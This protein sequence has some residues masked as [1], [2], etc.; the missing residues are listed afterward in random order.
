MNIHNNY[1]GDKKYSDY[2]AC[3]F[4]IEKNAT[5]VCMYIIFFLH[6]LLKKYYNKPLK[7][8]AVFICQYPFTIIDTLYRHFCYFTYST[9]VLREDLYATNLPLF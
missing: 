1:G 6:Y 2:R 5:R 3:Y 9:V 4:L 8:H 7:L